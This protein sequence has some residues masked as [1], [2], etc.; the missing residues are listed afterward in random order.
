MTAS[1][2]WTFSLPI[3]LDNAASSSLFIGQMTACRGKTL[4]SLNQVVASETGDP[5]G[6]CA[7]EVGLYK[8]LIKS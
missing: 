7:A 5:L 6:T 4:L 3:S 8:T 1:I 2:F